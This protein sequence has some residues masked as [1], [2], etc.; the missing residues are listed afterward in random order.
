M[1]DAWKTY[2]GAPALG[3][4]VCAATDVPEGGHLSVSLGDFSVIVLRVGEELRGYVNACPHQYLPLDYRGAQV[5]S[6]DGTKLICTNHDAT[7]DADN[8]QGLGGFGQGCWLDPVPLAH[9][10]G[11]IVIGD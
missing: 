5:V 4:T 9:E 6:A 3:K 10:N 7:F 2:P 11:K 8:G 1:S